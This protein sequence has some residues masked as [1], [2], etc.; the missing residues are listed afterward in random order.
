MILY[1]GSNVPVINPD[2]ALSRK[3]LDFGAGFYTTVN[4]DQ[5]LDILKVK[6]LYSQYVFK[7]EKA[8]SWLKY[9]DSFEPG[10]VL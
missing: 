5:T 4:K 7:T 6:K 1:H 9:K 10:A 3:S 2:L 8:L